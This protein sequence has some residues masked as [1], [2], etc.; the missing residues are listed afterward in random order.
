SG[1]QPADA[2][3]RVSLDRYSPYAAAIIGP[4][5]GFGPAEPAAVSEVPP[6]PEPDPVAPERELSPEPGPDPAPAEPFVP[7]TPLIS[8][9]P[10]ASPFPDLE[11]GLVLTP[12]TEAD[13]VAVDR[14]DWPADQSPPPAADESVLFDQE[15]TLSVLRHEVEP[16]GPR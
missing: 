14:P 8:A 12:A 15:P 6:P 3:T 9:A 1:F 11:S 10:V 5:P 16:A 4:L 7:V 13:F 2:V